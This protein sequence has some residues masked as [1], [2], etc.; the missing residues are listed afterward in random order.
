MSDDIQL[1]V[2]QELAELLGL[3]KNELEVQN[4]LL[5]IFELYQLG[6]ITLSK[7]ASLSNL[8]IDDFLKEF[9]KRRLLRHGG[10][11]SVEEAEKE[12]QDALEYLK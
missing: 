3:A 12:L 9:R 6:K 5:L 7:A 11:E 8:K 10:P 1:R 2:P 4:Q